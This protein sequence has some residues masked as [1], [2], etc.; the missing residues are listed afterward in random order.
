MKK[1]NEIKNIIYKVKKES[2]IPCIIRQSPDS[3]YRVAFHTPPERGGTIEAGFPFAGFLGNLHQF[4]IRNRS[5]AVVNRIGSHRKVYTNVTH[6][7]HGIDAQHEFI[8]DT[9]GR[10]TYHYGGAGM[11]RLCRLQAVCDGW[12][13]EM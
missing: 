7:M 12:Y 1:S 6:R 9:T 4:Q 10:A 13:I 2:T 8:R 11:M 3:R 5:N